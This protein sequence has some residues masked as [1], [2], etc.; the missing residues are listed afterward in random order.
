MGFYLLGLVSILTYSHP[1]G[2][3]ALT[4]VPR[5]AI[6]KMFTA[7]DNSEQLRAKLGRYTWK[8]RVTSAL[9]WPDRKGWEERGQVIKSKSW[10][11]EE[12]SCIFSCRICQEGNKSV[13]HI[14]SSAAVH[15]HCN[16]LAKRWLSLNKYCTNFD[17]CSSNLYRLDCALRAMATIIF[18]E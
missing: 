9:N 8:K 4:D 2:A 13:K 3:V 14:F 18:K 7:G 11:I 1:W 15:H 12:D 16:Y 6:Q 10:L 17:N 5:N